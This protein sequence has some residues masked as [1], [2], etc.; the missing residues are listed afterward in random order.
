MCCWNNCNAPW[1]LMFVAAPAVAGKRRI[2]DLTAVR[3]AIANF[4]PGF[5]NLKVRRKAASAYV[6]RQGPDLQCLPIVA[7]RNP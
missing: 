2:A 5:E 6:H 4:M 3:T 1:L 7:G